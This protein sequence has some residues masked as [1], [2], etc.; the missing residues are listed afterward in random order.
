[1]LEAGVFFDVDAKEGMW[2]HEVRYPFASALCVRFH[3]QYS[4][5]KYLRSCSRSW[6]H[7]LHLNPSAFAASNVGAS[8]TNSARLST[9]T[10]LIVVFAERIMRLVGLYG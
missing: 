9:I 6:L 1:M 10:V 4:S 3:F 8:S 2:Q 7:R 5:L